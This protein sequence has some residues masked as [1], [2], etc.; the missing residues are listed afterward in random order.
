M[1]R[2]IIVDD[3]PE[4]LYLLEFLLKSKGH[5]V[6]TAH[7]GAQALAFVREQMVDI[8]VTDILMPVMDGFELC[9]IVK[10]DRNLC[11]IPL[12]I[13]TA[14]Y[15][16]PE[17]EAFALRIGA[18]R[19]ILKP[20]EPEIF[21]TAIEEVIASAAHRKIV[22]VKKS[23]GDIYRVYSERIVKK[24][25]DKMMQ[26]DQSLRARQEAEEQVRILE[27]RWHRI[28]SAMLDPVALVK[29]D[30]TI[31]QCNPAFTDLLHLESE[32][33]IG[34][35]CHQLV[36][37][38]DEH[39]QGCPLLSAMAAGVRKDFEMQMGDRIFLV[40]VD[41]VRE[42]DGR[43]ESFVHIMRD[44]T[45]HRRA[46]EAHRKIQQQLLQSQKME[47]I[48]QLAG[49]IAHDFNNMLAVI[50]CTAE[51]LMQNSDLDKPSHKNLQQ[52]LTAAKH[53]RDLTMQLLAFARRQIIEPKVLDLNVA[54]PDMLTM[55]RRIITEDIELSWIPGA[56]LWL[57]S[58]DPAQIDQI[59]ANLLVN[60]RHA[61]SGAG[62]VSV[63]TEN[64]TID[65]DYCAHQVDAVPGEYVMLAVSDTGC[66]IA[67][68]ELAHVFEP[69][70]TTRDLGQGTGLGLATVYGIAR[71]NSGFIN[72]Y[73]ELGKG[74]TFRIYFP[75]YAGEPAESPADMV[76]ETPQ[77]QGETV[78][79]VE[80]E[81]SLL[82]IC[83]S[84]LEKLN[85]TVLTA[86]SP[87]E[88]IRLVSDYGGA[89][90]LLLTDVVMP[91]LNGR[92]LFEQLGQLRP[93]LKCLF[94]SGYT[95]DVIEH[96][97]VLDSGV[98]FIS[99]PFSKRELSIRIREAME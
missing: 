96:R 98:E 19:F 77:G 50:G 79:V 33:V 89:I 82:K 57:V 24:L 54:I 95:T 80:D 23:K 15:T 88:A 49:G 4:N 32:A 84:I 72:V 5:E 10:T 40:V 74:T 83:R 30:G 27:N 65:E 38:T 25:E 7:N 22:P 42:P 3:K 58:V 90:D 52:I 34:R 68:D 1:P 47:A 41:P 28:F 93:G 18:D 78:L 67:E 16:E 59:L 60:S 14:T 29:A 20:C 21:L 48:G 81:P 92:E 45:D 63:G 97:G 71:Q 11:H 44:I 51:M 62:R 26:L 55:L 85:Y 56:D 73:S 46:E 76:E 99:K 39:I 6:I 9:R 31:I 12:I 66:G 87:A 8:I 17:D 64:V 43:V 69:F 36:H 37:L 94:M 75:R 2:A 70:F 13:Y 61:I 35:K 91:Q 53:S 86:G